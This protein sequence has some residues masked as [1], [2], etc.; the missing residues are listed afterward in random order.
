MENSTLGDYM[1]P[2]AKATG[3]SVQS[4]M[5]FQDP[6]SVFDIQKATE[7]FCRHFRKSVYTKWTF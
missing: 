7:Q 2:H 3:K 1:I 5:K 6:K 4:Q